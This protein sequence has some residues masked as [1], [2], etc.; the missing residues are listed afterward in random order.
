MT[1]GA[2]LFRCPEVAAVSDLPKDW[3]ISAIRTKLLRMT[4]T[5]KFPAMEQFTFRQVRGRAGGPSPE[6]EDRE[7]DGPP[8]LPAWELPEANRSWPRAVAV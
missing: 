1:W 2:V 4:D 7:L 3:E 5:R 8:V 6:D